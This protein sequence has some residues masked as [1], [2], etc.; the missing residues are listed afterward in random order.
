MR[1]LNRINEKNR[2]GLMC[3]SENGQIKIRK[4]YNMSESEFMVETSS[5]DR[6]EK[7]INN[8]RQEVVSEYSR[9]CVY[10]LKLLNV[11]GCIEKKV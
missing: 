9:Y 2:N 7:M 10:L 5:V 1:N 4:Y 8:L 11:N 3:M 6:R